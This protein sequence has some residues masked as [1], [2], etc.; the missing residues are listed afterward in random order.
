MI[1]FYGNVCS[2]KK[3]KLWRRR[4]VAIISLQIILYIFTRRDYFA[5]N[6][7]FYY[8]YFIFLLLLLPSSSSSIPTLKKNV[9]SVV[10]NSQRDTVSFWS[11]NCSNKTGDPYVSKVSLYLCTY[12][13]TYIPW[14]ATHIIQH[15]IL[16]QTLDFDFPNKFPW[17]EFERNRKRKTF[18]NN[19]HT[20]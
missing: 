7:V 8:Y 16:P 5:K 6:F 3:K 15:T 12:V 14:C 4:E 10:N 20:R 11:E 19:I 13:N 9:D 17:E 1:F 2:L 18:H